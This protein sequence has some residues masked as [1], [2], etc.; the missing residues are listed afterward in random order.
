MHHDSMFVKTEMYTPTIKKMGGYTP[1][2]SLS[3]H[4]AKIH[5]RKE[6]HRTQHKRF[7]EGFVDEETQN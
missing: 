4:V 3:K 5:E 7:R 1:K 6:K 2:C